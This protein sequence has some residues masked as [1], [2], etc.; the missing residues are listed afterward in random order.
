MSISLCLNSQRNPHSFQRR[1]SRDEFNS[2]ITNGQAAIVMES[3]PKIRQSYFYYKI[4]TLATWS[5]ESV[6][7]QDGKDQPRVARV[8]IGDLCVYIS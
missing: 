2:E 1:L 7:S 8:L 4:W 3:T 5:S 6:V